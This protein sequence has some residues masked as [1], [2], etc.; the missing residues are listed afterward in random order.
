MYNI[1]EIRQ[2][3]L[4]LRELYPS[5]RFD[6]TLQDLEK[7]IEVFGV[8]V[9]YSYMDSEN[10]NVGGYLMVENHEPVI[11]L[12]AEDSE[13]RRRF[14][15]AH[16]LGHLILHWNWLPGDEVE[17]KNGVFDVSYRKENRGDYESLEE[18]ERE[19]EANTFAGEFLL[20]V[21]RVREVIENTRESDNIIAKVSDEFNVSNP[22]AI[23]RIRS[24]RQ[25]RVI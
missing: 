2:I 11:V 1:E 3:V 25:E 22:C 12:N 8:N 4:G 15:M 21:D 10:S 20:P 19:D 6:S 13:K 7:A 23:V 5:L 16:E 9:K 14:T 24:L 17:A 18:L